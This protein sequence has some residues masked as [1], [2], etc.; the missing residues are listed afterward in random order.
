[1]KITIPELHIEEKDGFAKNDIF[2]RK[3]FGDRLA[4][5]IEN[6]N[7][8]MVI[9]LD[10][11][12]GEGK[13]TF[14]KM[15]R[16]HVEFHRE[17]KFKTIYFDAFANDYQKDPFLALIS[18]I[19]DLLPLEEKSNFKEG[20][21][22]A[23]K[24][25]AWGSI[26]TGIQIGTAGIFD[27]TKIEGFKD[28][29]SDLI[30]SQIENII[31]TKLQNP[32]EDKIA[33]KSFKVYL[34]TLPHKI[35]EGKPIVFII[36]ELDRCRPDFAL[37][38]IEQVKHLFSVPKITFLL[39]TNKSQLEEVIKSKYGSGIQSSLYLQ[40]FITIWFSLPR[41]NSLDRHSIDDG[42]IY[43][44]ELLERVKDGTENPKLHEHAIA[45]LEALI[46]LNKIS[47]RQIE[48]VISYYSIIHNLSSNRYYMTHQKMIAIICYIHVLHHSLVEDILVGKGNVTEIIEELNL[49]RNGEFIYRSIKDNII[50]DLSSDNKGSEMLSNQQGTIY[51]EDEQSDYPKG[52]MK[53]IS[54]WLREINKG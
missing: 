32:K 35:N 39:V 34:E 42:N 3:D 26:K 41:R 27:G 22:K 47:F 1:M 24:S 28:N 11:K 44:N 9:A 4:N 52:L 10:S 12:W 7:D 8:N 6:T 33:I 19:Y 2:Q 48:R 54:L 20:A 53:T 17:S 36:D 13:S 14:I 49:N 51:K 40:K 45:V 31:E 29:I 16:G 43:L 18:E 15:W 46:R 21:K 25:F 23:F 5:L 37:E 50:F 30:S 38:L